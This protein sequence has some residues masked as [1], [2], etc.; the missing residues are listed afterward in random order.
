MGADGL[1]MTGTSDY[2]GKPGNLGYEVQTRVLAPGGTVSAAGSLITVTGADEATVVLAAGTTYVL[3]FTKHYRGADPHAAVT[4]ALAGACAKPFADLRAA[5]V[6]DYRSFFDRVALTLPGTDAAKLPTDERRKAYATGTDD[7]VLAAL[8]YQYGRFLM[9]CSSRPDN[10]LPSNSQGIWGDGMNMPW[11]SDYK[12]NINFQMNY[13]SVGPGNLNDCHVPALNL[14]RSVVIPGRKTAK[15]YFNAPGWVLAM[16]TNIW[17]HTSPGRSVSWGTFFAGGAWYGQHLWDHFAFTRDRAYLQ[18]VW[19]VIKESCEFYLAILIEDADG[20]LVTSPS[21]SPEN[22]FKTDTGLQSCVNEGVAM[23][24]QIIW[25]L[26]NNAALASAVLGDDPAFRDKLVKTRD[27]I[28]PPRIGK[29]G[30]LMEWGKDWDLNAQEPQHRHVSHLFALHPGRQ[31][32]PLTTP[33]LAAAAKKSLELRGD[34]GTGWSMAWKINFWARLHDGNHAALMFNKLL[35]KGTYDNLFDAHPP[36]QIDGNFGAVSGINEMLLQ[37]QVVS[38]DLV[39]PSIDRYVLHLLPALPDQWASGSIHGIR[40]RGGF[41]VDLEWKEM[42]L[43]STTIRSL[44][45]SACKVRYGAKVI[46]LAIPKGGMVEV[47]VKRFAP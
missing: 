11:H 18:E 45:D 37:S 5:H 3:D 33:D 30:Q 26:F 21:T 44:E 7:P 39:P 35:G 29:A 32:S 8:F 6:A 12:S 15:A 16:M 46:D 28:R 23:E 2:H 4:R 47:D 27:R 17:G 36:F 25:D 31:I 40:A 9:I 34:G 41:T 10:Q 14:M 13:W 43:V 1:I 22:R 20:F 24:C 19:P 38:L 42:K